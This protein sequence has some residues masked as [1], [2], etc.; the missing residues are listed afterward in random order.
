MTVTLKTLATATEQAIFDQVA[1]HMLTQM[2]CS[3]KSVREHGDLHSYCAYRGDDGRKCAIGAL[4]AD[5][6]YHPLMDNTGDALMMNEAGY[7]GDIDEARVQFLYD[8]QRIHDV[9]PPNLWAAEL[10]SMADKHG[11]TFTPPTSGN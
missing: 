10:R 11:L 8:L 5:D 7:F 6:E 1:T 3:K 9:E 4:I 2:V